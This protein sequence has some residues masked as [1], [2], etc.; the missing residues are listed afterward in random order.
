ML[1]TGQGAGSHTAKSVFLG[2]R[3]SVD[4]TL[5]PDCLVAL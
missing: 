3:D 4:E 1:R 2:V 5:T